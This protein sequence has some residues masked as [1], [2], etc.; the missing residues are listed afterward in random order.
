MSLMTDSRIL[1]TDFKAQPRYRAPREHGQWLLTPT[2]DAAVDAAKLFAADERIIGGPRFCGRSI[3][4]LRAEAK[5]EVFIAALVS[6]RQYRDSVPLGCEAIDAAAARPWLVAGH[7]P[8]LFHPGVWF[9]NFVLSRAAE[10]T[11]YLPL[12]LVIDNDLCRSPGIKVPTRRPIHDRP[13]EVNRLRTESVLFDGPAAGIPWECRALVDESCFRSFPERVRDV[14]ASEITEPL[15]SRLWPAVI[16][17]LTRTGRLGAALA[18]GRHGLE[19]DL[20][21][22]T[23]ELPLSRV[24]RSAAFARFSLEILSR[25]DAFQRSY[26]TQRS[27]YRQANSIRNEAHPV[28]ALTAKAGWFEAPFW[29]YRFSA[30]TRRRLFVKLQGDDLLLSDQAGW[31]TSIEGPLHSDDAVAQWQELSFD[32]AFVRPRALITTMFSRLA[33]ADIFLHGIGGGKYDQI[34]DAIL[35]DFFGLTPPPMCIATSTLTLP[36]QTSPDRESANLPIS[37]RTDES[38]A[39]HLRRMRYHAEEYLEYPDDE[40]ERLMQ[41]KKELTCRRSAAW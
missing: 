41:R 9:K 25:I 19:A 35:F 30:P 12:N 2:I 37:G 18:E 13:E 15:I 34:T 27:G 31:Q 4:E 11:G 22:K 39:I 1:P 6:T 10:Q 5:R 8:E 14:L 32:G 26:N 23:L 7:Q 21:L 38:P 24:C 3:A 29:V 20:G 40:A 28:P 33:L 17:S 36:I 16:E